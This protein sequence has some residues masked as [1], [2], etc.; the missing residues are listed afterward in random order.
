M[1]YSNR[2]NYL[3]LSND[4]YSIECSLRFIAMALL[5]SSGG[6]SLS[7]D[8]ACGLGEILK[9]LSSDLNKVKEHI[10]SSNGTD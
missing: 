10:D 5:Q 3:D 7:E 6:I 9:G 1:A 4:I 2:K 8:D